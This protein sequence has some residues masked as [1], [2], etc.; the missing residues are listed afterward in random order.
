MTPAVFG[1]AAFRAGIFLSARPL[2]LRAVTALGQTRQA[3]H[4]RLSAGQRTFEYRY[5]RV[6][7]LLIRYGPLLAC[8]AAQGEMV[9]LPDSYFCAC[10]L[11]AVSHFKKFLCHMSIYVYY[12]RAR[13]YYNAT[14]HII[15]QLVTFVLSVSP[16]HPRLSRDLDILTS[17]SMGLLPEVIIG[18][19]R[20]ST[21]GLT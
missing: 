16:D 10:Q 4:W 13:P 15:E 8:C 20:F 5:K 2:R 11:P 7:V 21:N 3:F 9:A 18:I 17:N 1:Y 14:I 19:A 12:A 6:F